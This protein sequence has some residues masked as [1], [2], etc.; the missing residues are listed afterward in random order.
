MLAVVAPGRSSL[1]PELPTMGEQGVGGMD[2]ESWVGWFGPAGMAA[3]T[4]ARLSAAINEVLKR[5][6]VR[7]Q[8]RLGG[9]EAK[10]TTPEQFAG[11]VRGTYEQWG[12]M[13][14]KIG[15]TKL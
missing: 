7:E 15:F 4:V 6:D 13:L 10:G 12:S 14:Q 1:F 9:A 11:I 5:P 8:Y 2:I 3:A